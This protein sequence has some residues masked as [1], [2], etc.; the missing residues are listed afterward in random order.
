MERFQQVNCPV[1]SRDFKSLSKESTNTK[2]DTA[3]PTVKTQLSRS[4]SRSKVDSGLQRR[5]AKENKANSMSSQDP[6]S[7]PPA[8]KPRSNLEN[9]QNQLFKIA[10]PTFKVHK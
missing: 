2:D 8:P 1:L 10:R 3:Q 5:K 4:L 6:E 9:L 7:S